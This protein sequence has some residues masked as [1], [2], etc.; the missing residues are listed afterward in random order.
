VQTLTNLEGS[1]QANTKTRRLASICRNT[2]LDYYD[3]KGY[4][5]HHQVMVEWEQEVTPAQ[6]AAAET[7][8][9]ETA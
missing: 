6:S 5:G 4:L 3:T 1:L 7:K 9:G 8:N 2:Y